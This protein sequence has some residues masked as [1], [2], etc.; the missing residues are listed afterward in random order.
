MPSQNI[1]NRNREITQKSTEYQGLMRIA[2]I[3]NMKCV[4]PEC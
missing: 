3:F 1:E 2:S 4:V